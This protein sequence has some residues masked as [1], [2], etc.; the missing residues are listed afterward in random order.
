MKTAIERSDQVRPY[1]RPVVRRVPPAM[2]GVRLRIQAPNLDRVLEAQGHIRYGLSCSLI[3]SLPITLVSVPVGLF[4]QIARRHAA[5]AARPVV[6][7]ALA[8][9][10]DL[11]AAGRLT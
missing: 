7:S 4:Y 11:V 1:V 3:N 10:T 9:K 5:E 8:P 2:M 6:L